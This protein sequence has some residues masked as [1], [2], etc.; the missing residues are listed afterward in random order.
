M[1]RTYKQLT[2]YTLILGIC[3]SANAQTYQEMSNTFG[4]NL[5]YGPTSFFGGGVS[6]VDFD[7]DG[8]DD[9]SYNS[10]AGT[11][12]HF[13]KNNGDGTFTEQTP[14]VEEL[15][16]TK[17]IVWVDFDNDGDKDLFVSVF[18]GKNRLLRNDGG[19]EFTDIS[20][21]TGF[22]EVPYRTMG[23]AWADYD[24]DGYLDLYE[25]VFTYEGEAPVNALWKNNGDGTF[26]NVTET[27]K[28]GNGGLPTFDAFWLDY[29]ND[30]WPDLYLANDKYTIPNALFLNDGDGT[31]TD[32]SASSGAGVHMD[33]MNAGGDDFDNDGDIDI[34]VTNTPIHLGGG[35]KML[36]NNG[37]GSFSESTGN[38][39]TIFDRIGWAATFLDFDNDMDKDLYVSAMSFEENQPNG[40]YVNQGIETGTYSFTE[41]LY[42]S[43]GLGGN[44]LGI[45]TSHAIGDLNNDGKLDIALNQMGGDS[46]MIWQ[47][48][49]SNSNNWIKLKLVGTSSNTDAVGSF[50]EVYAGGIKQVKYTNCSM[51]YLGQ[52]SDKYHFGLGSNTV[53]D[54]IIVRW[55]NGG[56]YKETYPSEL[57][58]LKT[59]LEGTFNAP[60]PLELVAFEIEKVTRTTAQLNWVTANEVNT[61][62]FE[63][64]RSTDAKTFEKIGQ[65][66]A[67][68]HSEH[69]KTYTFSDNRIDPHLSYYYR[70]KMID[71]DE[72][73][74]YSPL[75][76]IQA[77]KG[78]NFIITQPS[79]NP[80]RSGVLRI[81]VQSF[82]TSDIQMAL[83]DRAGQ[84]LKSYTW[85]TSEGKWL[86]QLPLTDIASGVYYVRLLSNDQVETIPL[87]ITK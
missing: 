19:M 32:V 65:L 6:F 78:K 69:L 9:L 86:L 51:G 60:F 1:Y 20:G 21:D 50:I 27:A 53:I 45:N 7:N 52:N 62:R 57:N 36:T 73:F 16:E 85:R 44:D 77:E 15:G 29:N 40:F 67:A 63:I 14:F 80:I 31:F 30:G 54:S 81:E 3:L 38:T 84:L 23:V 42:A 24:R 39:G 70:L 37:D 10:G 59:I 13:F 25:C 34:Y 18:A 71:Q 4:I 64:E 74:T 35:N 87:I 76:N 72:S 26:T 5:T 8:Y 12:L 17:E 58:G 48:N 66:A 49:E 83:F 68:G 82:K 79:E 33:A 43:G 61:D 22:G 47:N 46:H 11:G 75:R 28:V 55:P 56:V 2:I 41:P